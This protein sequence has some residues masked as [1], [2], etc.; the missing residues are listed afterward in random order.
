MSWTLCTSGSAI[1][2]AGTN[3]NSMF[4]PPITAET[5]MAEFSD[6]AEGTVCMKTRRDWITTPGG[7]QIMNAVEGAVSDLI[8]MDLINADTTGYLKG[9]ATLMMNKLQHHYDQTITDL[10]DDGN[11]VLNK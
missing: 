9:E 10:R 6:Q 3:V 2:K 1:V 11:Q 8:A 4:T 7:A 5:E